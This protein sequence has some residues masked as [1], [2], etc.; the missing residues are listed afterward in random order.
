MVDYVLRMHEVLG[1]VHYSLCLGHCQLSKGQD[2]PENHT[3]NLETS[4]WALNSA[5]ISL[6]KATQETSG[7]FFWGDGG[8]INLHEATLVNIL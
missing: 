7:M 1:R 3:Q 8:G 4:A 5:Q 2:E 6:A